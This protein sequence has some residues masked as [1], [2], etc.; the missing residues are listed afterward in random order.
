MAPLRTGAWLGLGLWVAGLA[1][2]RAFIVVP[3]A[4][5]AERLGPRHRRYPN[6]IG[7][8]SMGP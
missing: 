2:R 5:E 1:E 4:K 8:R 7:Q 3:I 6:C